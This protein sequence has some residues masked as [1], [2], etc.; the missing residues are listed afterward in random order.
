MNMNNK[1]NDY[2]LKQKWILWYH[3]IKNDKWDI[4]SY[5]KL[6]IIHNLFDYQIINEYFKKNHYYNGMFFIMR[7]GI[8]P[9]WEDPHNRLGG[10]ISF[11]IESKDIINQWDILIKNCI[12][13]NLFVDEN[14]IIN[15][16][17]ISPKKEFNIIKIW[18]KEDV[19]DYKNKM[20]NVININ[21]ILYRKYLIDK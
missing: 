2:N 3:S 8:N 15:G 17:S 7:E 6:L 13:E 16:I 11:K 18:L 5:D 1:M 4:G 21:N 19:T 14:H 10:Y 20:N 12:L 9:I